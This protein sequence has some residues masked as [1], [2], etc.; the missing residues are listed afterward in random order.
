MSYIFQG[1]FYHY[2][3]AAEIELRVTTA[4]NFAL[5]LVNGERKADCPSNFLKGLDFIRNKRKKE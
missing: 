1:C 3:P 5:R 2:H 4:A